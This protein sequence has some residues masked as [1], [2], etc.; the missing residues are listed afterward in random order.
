[1]LRKLRLIALLSI[2]VFV[3]LSTWLDRVYSTD[4][5]GPL[6]VALFPINAD[7][8]AATEKYIGGLQTQNFAALEPFFEQ[9]AY[10][11]GVKL[12]RP[13]RFVLAAPL[14]KQ[15]PA[16]AANANMLQAMWWS[17]RLRF[18]SWG[19]SNPP[20]PTPTVRLFLLY[21]DPDR[22]RSLPHSIGLQKGLMGVAHLFATPDMA[23]SNLVILAHE[24]LHTL[25]A[26][27]KYDL[28]NN[29]PLYPDGFADPE[30]EPRYPQ[31]RAELMAGRIPIS[32]TQAE[33]PESLRQVVIGPA[34]A[35]EIGWRK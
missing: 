9:Q 31:E 3:G 13:V 8:S 22:S 32:E 21:H 5:D 34:S 25:G 28:K 7:G 10:A 30:R 1:M 20:G 17:L 33:I 23:G 18:W 27:D 26:S 15:P 29:L 14:Q 12:D 6:L 35:K 4:W 24:F 19:V 11:Y 16:L 2:L